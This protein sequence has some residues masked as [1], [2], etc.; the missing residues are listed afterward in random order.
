MKEYSYEVYKRY[1]RILVSNLVKTLN[2]LS[3][4]SSEDMISFL[5]KKKEVF[6]SWYKNKPKFSKK[7]GKD[8]VPIVLKLSQ[9]YKMLYEDK[10]FHKSY[11]TLLR[12]G[13]S[14]KHME[15]KI[16]KFLLKLNCEEIN[17]I[18]RHIPGLTEGMN[19]QIDKKINNVSLGLGVRLA[20]F[21]LVVSVLTVSLSFPTKAQAT[22]L[23]NSPI[24]A[25]ESLDD[26][27][28]FDPNV[29]KILSNLEELLQ[30]NP[31]QWFR[32]NIDL[33]KIQPYMDADKD[34]QVLRDR[35]ESD[36]DNIVNTI[37]SDLPFAVKIQSINASYEA[38]KDEFNYMNSVSKVMETKA[39]FNFIE[40]IKTICVGVDDENN[41]ILD[42]SLVLNDKL[43]L[44]SF[45]IVH[46]F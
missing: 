23:V 26:G 42:I 6:E 34:P 22:K 17:V 30:E 33:A 1:N 27:N 3:A 5:K 21:L 39:N 8:L 43:Y 44:K 9:L 16:R 10:F 7:V 13:Q 12:E 18:S 25:V 37:S 32:E 24:S 41:L 35:F 28:S 31:E 19:N 38:K 14:S 15:E 20:Y 11:Y 29:K 2:D 46:S 36:V 4:D 40:V 45:K